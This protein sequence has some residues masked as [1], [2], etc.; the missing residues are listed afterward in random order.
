M[1]FEYLNAADIYDQ[2]IMLNSF[3]LGWNQVFVCER[4]NWMELHSEDH[5]FDCEFQ[6]VNGNNNKNWL[7]FVFQHAFRLCANPFSAAAV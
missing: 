7:T 1:L 3:L 6:T 2:N 4:E 5:L